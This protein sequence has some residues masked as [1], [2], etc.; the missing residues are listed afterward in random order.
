MN[1]A[2]LEVSPRDQVLH[3]QKSQFNVLGFLSRTKPS[4][5]AL[6]C[7]AVSVNVE[8]DFLCQF[9]IENQVSY[10][11]CFGNSLSYRVQLGFS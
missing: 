8:F 6:S 9:R 10:V 5:H 1:F 11:Q 3:V 2:Y 7:C 4:C